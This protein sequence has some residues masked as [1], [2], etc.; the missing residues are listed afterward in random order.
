MPPTAIES[1]T[2]ATATSTSD[3]CEIGLSVNGMNC[4]SCVAH[5]EKSI[6]AVPGVKA[7]SV[8]L[9]RSRASVTYDPNA[10]DPTAIA[11]ASTDAG[12]PAAPESPGIADRNVEEERLRRQVHETDAWFRRAVLGVCIW[13]PLELAHWLVPLVLPDHRL[14]GFH[15]WMPY[16][17]LAG[18][19]VALLL[20]GGAFYRSAIGALRRGTSNMD[21]LISMGA[22]VAYAYSLVALVGARLGWWQPI[23]HLYFNEAT[24][25][26]A[27]ISLGH[28]LE[29]RARSSAGSAV[30]E[31][32][33]LA[34]AMALKLKGVQTESV[35][36]HTLK[37]GDKVLVR[38]GDKVP[39]DGV[40]EAG[41][42]AVDESM[43]TGESV[44]VLRAA[45]D[46]VIGGTINREGRL[47]VRVT[48]VAGDTALAQ[49]VKLVER[50]EAAK[51]PVQKLADRISAVFV[52]AVLAIALLTG[53]G[54]FAWGT[55]HQWP[56]ARTWAAIANAVCSVLIIACPCALGLAVPA[57]VMV[58]TGMGA[59]RGI[60][61][62][63]V[64][65]LQKAERIDMVVLDKTGTITLG[66]PAVSKVVPA[67]KHDPA[68]ILR[69]AASAEQFSEHPVAQAIV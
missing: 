44:P 2:P 29:A 39:I 19:T 24:G 40:V 38:P 18:A 46:A 25:L 14:H 13:L 69:L 67:L 57:A 36:V 56:Q 61:F 41:R 62:R 3:A 60:L 21:T 4:A 6:A 53:I 31:L 26:L 65:A 34:P 45:G 9:S 28:W 15:T 1:N 59:K 50:A 51:P 35:P 30:R 55:T 68:E 66:K 20:V 5:V 8:S 49:I 54:W 52:P 63:D 48:R 43:L 32:L 22:T 47:T 64:E 37:V 16:A 10:V 17:T 27:L 7:V 12:Y 33:D 23:A 11:A 58:G 42:S